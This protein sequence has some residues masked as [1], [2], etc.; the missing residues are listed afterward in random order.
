MTWRIH[1]QRDFTGGE[2]RYIVPEMMKDNQLIIAQNCAMTA[3]GLLET[4][5]GK[6]KLNA[7]SL[8]TGGVISVHRYAKESG[9]KYLVVQH[10]T[11]LY[12]TTWDGSSTFSGFGAAIKTG[13]NAAK[14]RGRVWKDVLILT[15]GVDNP[16][17]FNGT[18]CTDLAGTPPKSKL[19]AVYGGRLWFVDAANPNQLRFSG[20]ENYGTWD[21]LDVIKLRDGDGDVIT[22]LSPQLGGLIVT[23]TRSVWPI[24]GTSRSDIRIPEQPL[25]SSVGCVATDTLIDDGL[26]LG[27]DN[28]YRFALNGIEEVADTHRS[29]I[30]SLTVSEAAASF[31]VLTPFEKRVTVGLGNGGYLNLEGRYNGITTW[32]SLN[33]GCFAV[34]DA[35]DDDGMLII[36]DKSNGF[37][38]KLDNDASDDGVQITTD[39]W[40]AYDDFETTRKKVWRHF[41]PEIE[42]LGAANY[43]I[44]LKHDID[45]GNN[46]GLFSINRSTIDILDW[47]VD[48]WMEAYWGTTQRFTD[49]YYMHGA[50]GNRISFRVTTGNRIKFLGYSTK[51]REAGPI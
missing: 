7:N 32:S 37:I 23:K 31:A 3:D 20:L 14:L 6:T 8:G 28:F 9:T 25:S 51:Y 48:N 26:F 10:G 30:S 33:A 21:A 39:I 49:P 5:R 2:N 38:Y 42:P 15:N 22:G 1:R 34:C 27:S 24:Y 43:L 47:N 40:T 41:I 36:G 17:L 12:A 46:A 45:Y 11:S 44:Y 19:I 50:R 29:V 13:L 18:T 16:F 35:K 4:R